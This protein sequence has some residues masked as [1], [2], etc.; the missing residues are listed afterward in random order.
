MTA[1]YKLSLVL[2]YPLVISLMTS[3][4]IAWISVTEFDEIWQTDTSK[5]RNI[6]EMQKYDYQECDNLR[7]R[8]KYDYL[9]NILLYF[10]IFG[11]CVKWTDQT[12]HSLRSHFATL[13]EYHHEI[14]RIQGLDDPLILPGLRYTISRHC[15]F[16]WMELV[17]IFSHSFF[18]VEDE[19]ARYQKLK[20]L[21]RSFGRY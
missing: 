12:S 15:P 20:L 5:N 3:S 7:I 17:Y 11:I 14:R 4:L 16:C 21:L 13:K 19:T 9:H 18:G 8:Q 10:S 6:T 2:D 1:F